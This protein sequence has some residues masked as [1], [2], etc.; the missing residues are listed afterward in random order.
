MM[1]RTEEN[2]NALLI[3]Q[4]YILNSAMHERR[5]KLSLALNSAL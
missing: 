5:T 1:H 3:D 2:G 4:V